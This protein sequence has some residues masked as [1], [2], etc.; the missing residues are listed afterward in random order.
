[1]SRKNQLISKAVMTK[2]R[3]ETSGKRRDWDGEAAKKE[4]VDGRKKMNVKK[5]ATR[6]HRVLV[7]SRLASKFRLSFLLLVVDRH[8]CGG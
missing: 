8:A 5:S 3:K 6:M 4:V 1:M 2:W 7:L